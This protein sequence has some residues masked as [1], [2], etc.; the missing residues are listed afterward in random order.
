MQLPEKPYAWLN[1]TLND[2]GP[3]VKNHRGLLFGK[4]NL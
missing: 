2:D 4:I 1:K 3:G